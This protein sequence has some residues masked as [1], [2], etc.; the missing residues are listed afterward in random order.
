MGMSDRCTG[1]SWFSVSNNAVS[2]TNP[3]KSAKIENTALLFF[4]SSNERET[5]ASQSVGDFANGLDAFGECWR[6]LMFQNH[7]SSLSLSLTW[8]PLLLLFLLLLLLLYTNTPTRARFRCC[9]CCC[10]C[11]FF[12]NKSVCGTEDCS[13]VYVLSSRWICMCVRLYIKRERRVCRET[14]TRRK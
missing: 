4:G 13:L 5:P 14:N 11:C 12:L 2:A 7:R 3:V 10:C 9:C 6:E 8:C 1:N